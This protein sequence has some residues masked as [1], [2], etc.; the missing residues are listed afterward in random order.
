MKVQF[1][2]VFSLLIID[3]DVD[4]ITLLSKRLKHHH[5]DIHAAPTAQA[6]FE[7]LKQYKIDVIL[8]DVM[9]PDCKGD[10]LIERFKKSYPSTPIIMISGVGSPEAI[11]KAMQAGASDYIVKPFTEQV[12]YEKVQRLLSMAQTQTAVNE[13]EQTLHPDFITASQSMQH[14][15][16]DVA[17]MAYLEMPVL[18]RG[19]VA[20]G[21]SLLAEIIHSYSSR[22]KE[23]LIRLSLLRTPP[24]NIEME[25][26]GVQEGLGALYKGKLEEASEGTL[27]IEDFGHLNRDLQVKLLRYFQGGEFERVGGHETIQSKARLILTTSRDLEH[28]V[29]AGRMR[30]DLF[31]RMS[32]LTLSI[33]P[34]RSR[35]EDIPL[36]VNHYFNFY[37]KK[38]GKTLEPPS[39]ELMSRLMRYDWPG[40]LRELQYVIERSVLL[41]KGSQLTSADFNFNLMFDKDMDED[42]PIFASLGEVEYRALLKKLEDSGGNISKAAK[43]LGIGRDT[44]Y[45]RLRKF[46]VALRRKRKNEQDETL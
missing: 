8:L 35:V 19:E 46:N 24:E 28:E 2:R 15:M 25:L 23:P 31:Y 40:N 39:D 34:L 6:G 43:S 45:R 29:K 32:T 10:D 14:L 21:K 16:R 41:S 18:I 9:L 4:F 17:R 20:T 33:P 7:I 22:R 44:I 3:D 36:L 27:V 30:D 42:H 37:C 11:V 12:V 1:S 13:L 5:F 38:M 26:F